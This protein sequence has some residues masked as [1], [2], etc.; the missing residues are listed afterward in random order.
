MNMRK[1]LRSKETKLMFIVAL[2]CLLSLGWIVAKQPIEASERGTIFSDIEPGSEY[3]E[4]LASL[5]QQEIIFGYSDGTYRTSEKLNREQAAVIL[6]RALQLNLEAVDDPN[7]Q[8]VNESSKYYKS[9][10]AI[11]SAGIFQGYSDGTFKPDQSLTRAEMAKILVV[12]YQLPVEEL[13]VNPFK[14]VSSTSWYAPYLASLIQ[15]KITTGTSLTTYSPNNVVTRGEIALFIYR[16]QQLSQQLTERTIESEVTTIT[17]DSIQLGNESF[18]LTN[19]QKTWITPENLPI[20]KKSRIKAQIIGGKISR[21]EWVTLY[22]NGLLNDEKEN[23]TV[24]LKGNSAVIDATVII[25]GD[26]LSIKDATITRDLIIESDVQKSFYLENVLVKG[27]TILSKPQEIVAAESYSTFVSLDI[28][29]S[30]NPKLHLHNSILQ[31]VKVSLDS[32]TI[33]LTGETKVNE[34]DLLVD[35][36]IEA[37]ASITIP[38]V[39][40]GTDALNIV[41]NAMIDSLFIENMNSRINLNNDAKIEDLLLELK[42]NVTFIFLN[43]ELIKHKII[44]INGVP[45]IELQPSAGGS[46]NSGENSNLISAK[47]AVAWL[48][49]NSTKTALKA[50]VDQDTID[51]ASAKVNLVADG[52]EKSALVADLQ[53]AQQLL[54][55]QLEAIAHLQAATEAVNEL[56]SDS[57]KTAL[58][59]GVDQDTIDAA[60]AKVNLVANGTEKSALVAYLQFAQQLLNA[61]LEAIAHLQAA[62]EAVNELFSDSTKTALKAGVGQ[63]T[64]DTAKAKVNLVADVTE[65]SALAADLQFAQQ[66]LNAQLEAIAH[67]QAATEAVNGLFTDSTKIALKAGVDQDAIDAASAKV[68]LVADGAE[69]SALMADLQFAQQLLNAQLEAIAHLQAATEAVNGLFS[70]ST[71]TALKAGVDQDTIDAANAKVNLV[72]D[73]AEKSALVADLQFA[74]QLLNA[75]LEAIAHLQAATEAVN[76]LF[77]D[78][79]KTALKAG[80][81]Q[82]AI[83]TAKAKVNLVADGAEKSALMADLQFAQQLL[84]AQFEAIAHLQAA[85]EAVNGLFSDSTKTALKAGV[86]QDA[87]D[88]ANA[89]VNLVAYGTEKSALMA[90]LQFAQQLLNAQ[91]EAIAHLQAAIE[92]VNELF[93][94]S[95][96]T[97]LKAG[98]NQDAIDTAKAKVNLV[99][100][101][102]EKSALMADLQFAQQLLNAQ[103]EAIAHLQAATEA[104]NGLFTD[105]TKI[106]LKAGVDQDAIDDANAKVNLV[107]NGTE[108]SALMANL[109]F[110]QQLLNAQLEAIAHLQ[111]AIEAVNELFLDS[112]KT[113]LKAGVNQDAID[114]AKAKVNLVAD[115]AEKSA[116]MAD[117]QF[118]Q[119]LLNAQLEA[120]AHLLAATEAVNGLF[121]DSTK[122][123]LKAGVDQDAIDTASAKVNLVANGAEKSAL[124]Q[125]IE[126]AQNLLTQVLEAPTLTGTALNVDTVQISFSDDAAWRNK[127]SGVYLNGNSVPIHSSRV[128]RSTAGVID[129]NLTG[130]SLSPGTHQ[131]SIKAEGYADAVVTIEVLVPLA[132][133]TLTG[134]APNVDTVHISFSDDAAWRNKITGVYQNGNSVPIHSSRVN[135]STAGVIDIN[136]TGAALSPGTHQFLIKA[137]GYADAVVTIEVLV[138]LA[139]PTLTGT[140]PNVDTVHISFSDDAAWRN[141]I[142]G[143]Y[144]NGNSVP[145]HSSRVNRSTAGGIDINLTG[146]SLSPGTHQ[147]LIKAEGYADA[148]V[149]IEVDPPFAAPTLTGTAPNVDTVQISFS[150]DA[151]WRN[152]IT[153]VYLNGNSVPIHS[154]RV[155]RSTAGVIDINLTGAALSPGTHQFLIKAEGY[156]DAVVTIE[157]DPPFAAPTLTG[158]APNVDTVQISFSD[159]A[160][161]RNKITGVYLNGNSVPI[162]SSRVNRSTAGGIEINLTDASLI[163]GTHQFLIKAEGYADAMAVI[164][165]ES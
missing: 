97:A 4:A 155:N 5:V 116:L 9:I 139:A 91:L 16:C 158:T 164:I 147:F 54:N 3:E 120:I 69:K 145:I 57:T 24:V 62:T 156:A 27:S 123:A 29:N 6:A 51:A 146:A 40:V 10:A 66:L 43:Y 7:F 34:I 128:N 71:K 21:I 33:K 114:T 117:L 129:I 59:A 165:I 127:I 32:F 19:D 108:K 149:T 18:A 144:L 154:S 75:Q 48:F 72:A 107:A 111:A 25:K 157:V 109:Q 125:A 52:A 95:T 132:A 148:V 70:D 86:D 162:H 47:N 15:N 41:L 99:A 159:D 39:R 60:S 46:P 36:C 63:D 79:T 138:P 78:S 94:D 161:W 31:S 67:L 35:A 84:N 121:S 151:A 98:V 22:A 42:N 88:D 50:G 113:A 13:A 17:S 61:Q 1:R 8:D 136:L 131:F 76:G 55:A 153:G 102:A 74:Q 92:A 143:V 119:Q 11:V 58:K 81:D 45:N 118:A 124:K 106:A 150:D 49:S 12:A 103:L 30:H 56:F 28:K 134:T 126:I 110:A 105:S 100:D 38:L 160:A 140:A 37:D 80:V 82:D 26:N 133:P 130:A 90:D 64:I 137:E 23:P 89:K 115:G 104:V 141:K 53:F 2:I 142:T 83:D 101:G 68:N 135:R 44:R 87:I 77:S 14:D 93:L 122:T 73:G 112:T 163:P 65:K 85:T 20:L 96:K 152:K